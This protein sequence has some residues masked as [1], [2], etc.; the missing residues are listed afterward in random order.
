MWREFELADSILN[1][2]KTKYVLLETEIYFNRMNPSWYP[3]ING[4]IWFNN[5]I[6][7][8]INS[9]I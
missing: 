1:M 2:N 4:L 5:A 8:R 7:E 9:T 3:T 6:N